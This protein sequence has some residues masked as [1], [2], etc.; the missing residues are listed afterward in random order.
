[1]PLAP[2]PPGAT[3]LDEA[4]S[5]AIRLL[6]EHWT[7]VRAVAEALLDHEALSRAEVRDM[8]RVHEEGRAS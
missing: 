3:L 4:E 8:V 7:L 5:L 6:E 2:L 1:M